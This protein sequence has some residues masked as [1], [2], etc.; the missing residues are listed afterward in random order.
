VA[1]Q[2]LEQTVANT[3]LLGQ[4]VRRRQ[5][6][7]KAGDAGGAVTVPW[8]DRYFNQLD[9]ILGVRYSSS[10][11][12]TDSSGHRLPHQWL[13]DGRSTLDAVGEWFTL[14]TPDQ[15]DRRPSRWPLHVEQL[16]G[17]QS[18]LLVRPDGH[19]AAQWPTTPDDATLEQ[20]PAAVTG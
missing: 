11:V 7:L 1:A 13:A 19:V 4:A 3:Q 10:A 6:Q 9:L 16:P 12:L 14:F 8:S 18:A 5:E 15:A 2:T 17:A 20:A